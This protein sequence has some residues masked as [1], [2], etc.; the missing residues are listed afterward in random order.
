M[1]GEKTRRKY[2]NILAV[3][4]CINFKIRSKDKS[5]FLKSNPDIIATHNSA[6]NNTINA[7]ISNT[8]TLKNIRCSMVLLDVML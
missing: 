3:Y 2:S 4:V 8:E 7:A 5:Y 6:A 1:K